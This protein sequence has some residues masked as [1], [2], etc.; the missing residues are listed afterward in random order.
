MTNKTEKKLI[1]ALRP[2]ISLSLSLRNKN[3]TKNALGLDAMVVDSIR[4]VAEPGDV[5]S[6]YSF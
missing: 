3:H 4:E 5:V 2:L 1:T 6:L